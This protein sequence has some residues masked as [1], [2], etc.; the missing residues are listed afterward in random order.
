MILF[1]LSKLI[2]INN[3]LAVSAKAKY[4][5]IVIELLAKDINS[6]SVND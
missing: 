4:D 1:N 2:N 6:T 3:R 5:G